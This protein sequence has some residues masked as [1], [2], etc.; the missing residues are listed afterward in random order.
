MAEIT[1]VEDRFGGGKVETGEVGIETGA[2][3]AEIGYCKE[4][5]WLIQARVYVRICGQPR[6]L[7]S[8]SSTEACARH[9][10]NF[11]CLAIFDELCDG[12][13]TALVE[14]DGRSAVV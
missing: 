1:N 7:T 5:T 2:R 10:D 13:E 4:M 14:F 6:K 3:R 9:D 8:G 12:G 11:G